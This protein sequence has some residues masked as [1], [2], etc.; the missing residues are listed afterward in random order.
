MVIKEN[1]NDTRSGKPLVGNW[2]YSPMRGPGCFLLYHPNGID[3]GP[4]HFYCKPEELQDRINSGKQV[5]AIDANFT[6]PKSVEKALY[7]MYG[8][9][10]AVKEAYTRDLKKGD[11]VEVNLNVKKNGT[12]NIIPVKVAN[13]LGSEFYGWAWGEGYHKYHKSHMVNKIDMDDMDAIIR[14]YTPTGYMKD[15]K[16]TYNEGCLV[17]KNLKKGDKIT[18]PD[19]GEEMEVLDNMGNDGYTCNI[20]VKYTKTGEEKT[21]NIG[22][23][24]EWKKSVTED[25]TPQKRRISYRGYVI[26]L[27]KSDEGEQYYDIIKPSWDTR[28]PIWDWCDSV[29]E[30]KAWIDS[31]KDEPFDES[32]NTGRTKSMYC[33]SECG[34]QGELFDDECE[35]LC[36][37]KCH[38]HHGGFGKCEESVSGDGWVKSGNAWTK[39]TK[40][41]IHSVPVRHAEGAIH[42]YEVLDNGKYIGHSYTLSGAQEIADGKTIKESRDNISAVVSK[43]ND[44]FYDEERQIIDCGSEATCKAIAK[45]LGIGPNRTSNSPVAH[46]I[47]LDESKSI[48]ESVE[49]KLK[50]D[51]YYDNYENLE[52]CDF[53]EI[54]EIFN[55][56]GWIDCSGNMT[57]P[58]GTVLTWVGNDHYYD[59]YEVETSDGV[60]RIPI[61]NQDNG[62]DSIADLCES[63]KPEY[64]LE[65]STTLKDFLTK[66]SKLRNK[67]SYT[68]YKSNFW[69]DKA[70]KQP[71]V[72]KGTTQKGN[73]IK[74]V[75]NGYARDNSVK[76]I[77]DVNNLITELSLQNNVVV[78]TWS[79]KN[80]SGPF[81]AVKVWFTEPT[82]SGEPITEDV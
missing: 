18:C 33:C 46:E 61:L 19:S 63:F 56:E 53:D 9:P 40:K 11:W 38:D 41:I 27:R 13:D 34:F 82:N 59:F 21:H 62:G 65:N 28:E 75:F 76:F 71:V 55:N 2:R 29:E 47:W 68:D 78:D 23:N 72:Y 64:M 32:V 37:P 31:D 24:S 10:N 15:G 54:I 51:Y 45:E 36:C 52:N 7:R 4:L 26:R 48:K 66:L 12:P 73:Y 43:Y 30:A 70:V 58:A 39:G 50:S 5:Y 67:H 77:E 3:T 79:S 8:K 69:S 22:V 42:K 6:V 20:K 35:D 16:D 81:N 1:G 80:H 25:T 49:Y 74:Y 17:G 57:I 44:A 60:K 14:K